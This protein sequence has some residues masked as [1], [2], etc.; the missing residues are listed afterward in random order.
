M[1]T[2]TPVLENPTYFNVSPASV[3]V[4][5]PTQASPLTQNFC[6]TANGI[7]PDLEIML[8]PINPARP[9]FDAKY[10]LVCRNK[11]NQVQSGT[12]TLTFDNTVA[13]VVTAIPSA[14]NQTASTISWDFVNLAPYYQEEVQLTLHLNSPTDVPPLVGGEVLNFTSVVSSAQTDETPNDNTFALNQT[15]VNSYDPNDKTCLQGIVVGTE[16]V[17]DYVHYVIRFENTGTY[18]AQNIT[19]TDFIDTNKF[20]INSLVPLDGSHLF[21]T[22]ISQG[23]KVEFI[24]DNINL[25]FN[26]A[27]NDGYVAFK[28]KTK[29]T[30]VAGDTFTNG[31]SIYFDY[32]AAIVTNDYTTTIQTLSNPDFSFANYFTVYPN[33]VDET[34]HIAKKG[35]I[36]V[37]SI[38]IYN[39][40]GQL[41]LAIPNSREVATVDVSQLSGGNYFVKI[42]SD[43]GTSSTKFIKR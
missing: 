38:N 10:R 40:L 25:P 32:N 26:D 15:V 28:I 20:D 3:N 2:V 7:H 17:G 11:G 41:V 12:L 23:N 5:F 13:S 39:G 8:I 9:D 33:P 1:Y 43:K 19:V 16:K 18:A 42:H 35:D 36:E 24:F 4:N 14:T 29:A 27:N 34:L 31:A 6:V 21:I 30:L 37:Q 22:K